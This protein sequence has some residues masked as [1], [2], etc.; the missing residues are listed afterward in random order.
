MPGTTFH[1][2]LLWK[3]VCVCVW[4][5]LYMCV[6]AWVS[7]IGIFIHTLAAPS[8]CKTKGRQ[9]G[10]GV[11]LPS[12]LSI[13]LWKWWQRWCGC[14]GIGHFNVQGL[15]LYTHH[16]ITY[17]VS[18]KDLGCHWHFTLQPPIM[19]ELKNQWAVQASLFPTGNNEILRAIFILGYSI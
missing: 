17:S 13:T 7:I 16:S 18:D 15:R 10:K 8:P 12:V 1:S 14:G 3:C 6:Y 19:V 4:G 11:P 2:A 5:G 9:R